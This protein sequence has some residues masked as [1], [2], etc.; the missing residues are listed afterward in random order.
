MNIDQ[1]QIVHEAM[2][3]G[4]W[5]DAA[6]LALAADGSGERVKTRPEAMIA[7]RALESN[8]AAQ[9]RFLE[10]AVLLWGNEMFD[11]R[12]SPVKQV[13]DAV[14]KESKLLIMG[15]SSLTK[16]FSCGVL[17][18]LLWRMDPFWTAV[19]LAAP[20]ETALYTNLFSHLCALHRG[21]VM[22]MTDDDPANISVNETDMF[23]SM[24]GALP[25]M[26]IQ[27]ILCKQSQ[28]STGALRGHKPKTYRKPHH[29]VLGSSTRLL[30][31]IDEA[32]EVSPGA[33][34]DI[35]TTEASINSEIGNIKIVMSF[36][37]DKMDRKVVQMAEPEGGY[38]IDQVDKL[39][40]WVSK[41]GYPVLR[42]DGARF[43]NVTQRRCIYRNM[44]TYE[45][46]LN[47]LKSG[48]H[49]AEYWSKARGFP[50]LQDNAWTIVP[51]AWMQSQRG[52]PIYIGAVRNI[53]VVDPAFGGS[54][55]ALMG[56]GRFGEAAGWRPFTG[57]TVWFTDNLNQSQRRT[58]YV[59]VLD[60]I[61]PLGKTASTVE[62]IQDVMGRCNKL[63]IKPEDVGMDRTGTGGGV[64]SHATK[65]WGDVLGI[66]FGASASEDKVLAEDK[67]TAY[68]MYDGKVSEL[69]YAMKRWLDPMV[70]AV[71]VNQNV[72]TSP[73]FTQITTRRYRNV[74]GGRVR[75]EPKDEY[76]AR[77]S[78]MSPDEADLLCMLVEFI[79]RRSDVIPGIQEIR[80]DQESDLERVSLKTAD[81]PDTM[82]G[83]EWVPGRMELLTD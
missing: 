75:V 6:N 59:A 45:S 38:E 39:Y 30:I 76:R 54:D 19:K 18:Y 50:P 49:S 33:F 25:E 3:S 14:L 61:F 12:P 69:W 70:C 22:P 82:A 23:I 41:Q 7:L 28:V 2:L 17:F 40:S 48:E 37:P 53:A 44:M 4:D 51:P 73:L 8:L 13:F 63:G 35:K 78:G 81:V 16:T 36:N 79:R 42:L 31:L 71:L 60:Q 5:I 20:S 66:D 29:P 83:P 26:R 77:N 27:G 43:E 62:I 15:G 55:K 47:F 65:F 11:S 32:S 58:Q 64:W 1:I 21:A 67:L 57:E 46:Y 10:V 52:D 74:K 56:I 24:K 34:N 80:G 9:E 72:P 68:E